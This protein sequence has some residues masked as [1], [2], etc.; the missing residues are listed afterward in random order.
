MNIT[1]VFSAAK[2]RVAHSEIAH[3]AVAHSP[4]VHF[5]IAQ[6][7]VAQSPVAQSQG[8]QSELPASEFL[9]L[10]FDQLS[11]V[12][13]R[14][15]GSNQMQ[16][17]AQV[18][19][20][21]EVKSTEN[22]LA[23]PLEK[24][25]N[26][27]VRMATLGKN[28]KDK[29]KQDTQEV[30]S[31]PTSI[32][33]Q[34]IP[35]FSKQALASV[36]STQTNTENSSTFSSTDT[37]SSSNTS[38]TTTTT[39]V[40][41]L[42][43]TVIIPI[44][45]PTL[46]PRFVATVNDGGTLSVFLTQAD[47]T[48][49]SQSTYTIGSNPSHVISADF[50]KD[51]LPDL[52]VVSVLSNMVSILLATGVGTFAGVTD[53]SVGLGSGSRSVATGDFNGDGILDL[54]VANLAVEG[55]ALTVSIL[56][57]TGTGGFGAPT[58]FIVGPNPTSVAV[59]DFNGDGI[60]DLVVALPQV[61]DAQ[62]AVSILLGTGTG[63]FITSNTLPAEINQLAIAIGDFN[64]DNI[65][66]FA[67][68]VTNNVVSIFLGT[69]SGDFVGPTNFV[70]GSVS[71]V[72]FDVVT[73]DFNGDGNL[74]L[75]IADANN[76]AVILLGTGVG[77]FGAPTS[78]PAGGFSNNVAI[79]DLNGDGKLDLVLTNSESNN[80]SV[81]FGNGDGS[82]APP[83]N[84]AVTGSPQGLTIGFLPAGV[85]GCPINLALV[86]PTIDMNDIVTVTID[87]IPLGWALNAAG[88]NNLDG[89][90]T[91]QTSTPELLT[92]TTIPDFVGARALVVDMSWLTSDGA[93]EHV[94][95]KDNIEAYAP[96]SPVFA[97][98]GDNLTGSPDSDIFVISQSNSC[99]NDNIFNFDIMLDKIDLLDFKSLHDFSDL[100]V[101]NDIYGNALIYLGP[102]DEENQ[103]ILL[104]GVDAAQVTDTH[105]LFNIMPYTINT[106]KIDVG[107]GAIM[108]FYGVF[109]NN[110]T[111][112]VD[113]TLVIQGD[114][115][116]AGKIIL[117]DSGV[118]ELRG[119]L[120]QD[121]IFET[122][123]APIIFDHMDLTVA[124]MTTISLQ[125]LLDH[126]Q[127]VA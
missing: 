81:L 123:T 107:A 82:F 32:N 37:D 69:G 64:N 44:A 74:D 39:T 50:N 100:I 105:F 34:A 63:S 66:D 29:D 7:S 22:F 15:H 102:H 42:P 86:N 20:A 35:V 19:A 52:A 92:I 93:I 25:M 47:G 67:T 46:A 58:S 48:L 94:Y 104:Y 124:S 61:T 30:T 27:P 121:I 119:H 96:G 125:L 85:S 4:V 56:L 110:G 1:S 114:I 127:N 120:F 40:V 68:A 59:G 14:T 57:G 55:E 111:I 83:M 6:S 31:N 117:G 88:V 9:N 72:P 112:Q 51:G 103:S 80:V 78:Y 45:L 101:Q 12:A 53:F 41:P 11:R 28:D 24:L 70:T 49:G 89:S 87:G 71:S 91:V 2:A 118:L 90:W 106:D 38:T 10:S 65:L 113:G 115:I 13:V 8:F 97:L 23:M 60:P 77:T 122:S 99:I 36:T 75:A 62:G 76:G 109:E 116:G 43:P 126:T 26:L 73:A 3:S 108:P 5:N 84:Y 79:A 54:A 33:F 21:L 95:C 16:N 98:P 18:K 17:A